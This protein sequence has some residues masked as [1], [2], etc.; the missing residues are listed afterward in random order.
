MSLG[1][2]VPPG[3]S[4]ATVPNPIFSL[5][6]AATVDEGNNW[7]N[8]SWGPLSL[9]NPVTGTPL[10][11]Y[12]PASASPVINLHPV[13][14]HTATLTPTHWRPQPT[15]SATRGRPT[16]SLTPARS[17]SQ[18]GGTTAIASVTGGPL[19]FGNV[20]VGTTSAAQ[21]LTL[22]NTGTA[23]LTGITVVVTAP[24]SRP[25]GAAGGTC[26]AT[27]AGG[28]ATCT[29]NVVFSPTATGAGDRNAHHHRQRCG[30]RLAG[31]ADW[32]G[33]GSGRERNSH[34]NNP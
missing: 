19:A 33:R 7:I 28:G 23:A 5:T 30:H 8:I 12:G 26:G 10:G 16:T 1:Y 4:D 14:C 29:I 20:A 24:F 9:T 3:I 31:Y 17:S 2:Q 34:S 18:A 25:A 6:P 11:N 27:L 32:H 22:H 15:S 13:H 21:T